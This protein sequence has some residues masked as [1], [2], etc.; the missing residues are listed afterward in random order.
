MTSYL[1]SASVKTKQALIG[2]GDNIAIDIEGTHY[3]LNFVSN[4]GP[5]KGQIH[6]G[7]ITL[8]NF[9]A[10]LPAAITFHLPANPTPKKLNLIFQNVGSGEVV[11]RLVTWSTY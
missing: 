11:Y 1:Q 7:M 3:P 2:P 6:D 9:D 4:G 10:T 5:Q 8:E